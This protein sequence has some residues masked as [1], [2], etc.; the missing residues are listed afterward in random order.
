M[1][2]LHGIIDIGRSPMFGTSRKN[3]IFID[4]PQRGCLTEKIDQIRDNLT[5]YGEWQT[6]HSWDN[7]YTWTN[8]KISAVKKNGL[9]LFKVHVK[10]DFEL[11]CLCPT[12]ERAVQ[13][14]CLYQKFIESASENIGWPTWASKT[15]LE[16]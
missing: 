2:N 16:P 13:M 12:V 6:K 3:Q 9:K 14:A 10:C 1:L 11:S 4:I 15:Q 8:F 5:S 7:S